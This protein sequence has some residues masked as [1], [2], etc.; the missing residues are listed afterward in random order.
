M[1]KTK[2]PPICPDC[3]NNLCLIHPE[4]FAK[5]HLRGVDKKRYKTMKK[6]LDDFVCLKMKEHQQKISQHSN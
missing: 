3:G 2:K 4:I 5:K 1:D 6:D